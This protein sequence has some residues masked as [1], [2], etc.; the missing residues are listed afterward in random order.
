MTIRWAE[1]D[2]PGS[3]THCHISGRLVPDDGTCVRRFVTDLQCRPTRLFGEC[4]RGDEF[5]S[6]SDHAARI[7]SALVT[8]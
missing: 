3:C 2:W 1:R 5:S 6:E 8:T 7:R 4:Y